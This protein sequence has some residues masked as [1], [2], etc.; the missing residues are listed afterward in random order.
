METTFIYT[1]TDPLNGQIRYVGK[2]N[3]LTHRRN[4]HL[5]KF[6]GTRKCNWVRSLIQKGETPIM[7]VLD[8]VPVDE[9]QFWEC[10]W[11]AQIKAWGY[12]LY[13]GDNGGLG[14]DRLSVA[15][16]AQISRVLAGRPNKALQKQVAQYDLQGNYI[17]TFASYQEAAKSFGG[18]HSNICRVQGK[19]LSTGGFLW[20]KFNQEK[21]PMI[22]E[23]QYDSRGIY[24]QTPERR[25]SVGEKTKQRLLGSKASESA[26]LKMSLARMGKSPANKGVKP[27]PEQIAKS[28]AT[29]TTKV[30]IDQYTITGEF[31]RQWDSIKEASVNTGI[32]RASINK[33]IKGSSR[34]AGGFLWKHA[35]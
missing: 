24:I 28:R 33:N 8:I 12:Q 9:W 4:L 19:G 29:C 17:Q 10:Y 22:I 23:T 32:A 18:S 30:I 26:K 34:H 31:V 14:S 1:L 35:K 20:L 21:P 11:I 27:T 2:A 3:N 7:E 16:K 15:T 6:E 5:R 25:K 13:N